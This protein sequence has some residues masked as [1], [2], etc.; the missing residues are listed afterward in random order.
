M[1]MS[2]KIKEIPA[3]SA[4]TRVQRSVS[5]AILSEVLQPVGG[6]AS[7]SSAE[8]DV[9]LSRDHDQ[10]IAR[11][12]L[13]GALELPCSRCLEP[14][15][16]P[17]KTRLD[18]VFEREGTEPEADADID[19]EDELDQP[20]TFHHDGVR[21]SL[22]EPIRELLIAELPISALCDEACRG[23]CPTCGANQNTAEGRACGH[24]ATDPLAAHKGGLAALS[25]LKIQSS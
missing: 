20:D 2:Y 22:D 16:V 10:V 11:G 5:P 1:E 7:K 23:L 24:V 4:P 14:A 3:V 6:D 12:Q 25:N 18:L 21:L 19:V 15:R 8:I 13:R 9:E 17:I